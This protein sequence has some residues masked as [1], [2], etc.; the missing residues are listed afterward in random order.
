MSNANTRIS[1]LALSHVIRHCHRMAVCQA[2]NTYS[3]TW[4]K[5]FF[6]PIFSTVKVQVVSNYINFITC[7]KFDPDNFVCNLVVDR[8]PLNRFQHFSRERFRDHFQHRISSV[9]AS[10]VLI[11]YSVHLGCMSG[12]CMFRVIYQHNK[13]SSRASE[14]ILL[15]WLKS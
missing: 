14:R 3:L 1:S 10:Y 6:Y 11:T 12:A 8:L 5:T 4:I 9:G 15:S 13:A 2:L 7:Q